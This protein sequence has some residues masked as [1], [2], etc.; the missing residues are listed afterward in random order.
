MRKL[1]LLVP[2]AALFGCGESLLYAGAKVERLCIRKTSETLPG[3]SSMTD[4]VLE[5]TI[6]TSI[7]VPVED[8]PD[9]TK[10]GL[11][12]KVNVLSFRIRAANGAL[13]AVERLV[14]R[15]MPQPGSVREPLLLVDYPGAS[16]LVRGQDGELTA[17]LA[18]AGASLVGYLEEESLD[19]SI[20]ASGGLPTQDWSADVELCMEVD[21]EYDY[22]RDVGL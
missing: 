4:D 9:L 18:G 11:T 3:T 19:V 13:D 16:G 2:L 17:D 10:E 15:V 12:A 7:Q 22:G 20:E 8:A 5:G 6:R 21:G 1:I 14:V